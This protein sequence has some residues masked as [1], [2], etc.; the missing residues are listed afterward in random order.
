M[1]S[2]AAIGQVKGLRIDLIFSSNLAIWE[3]LIDFVKSSF[4][5][6]LGKDT[7]LE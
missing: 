7:L 2:H 1:V 4:C 6:L 3:S 5:T